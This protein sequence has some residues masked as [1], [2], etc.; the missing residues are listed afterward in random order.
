MNLTVNT[1]L[2]KELT[3]K[4]LKGASFNKL[5]PIT[6][7][8]C[9]SC[10]AGKLTLRTTDGSNYLYINQSLENEDFYA[11]VKADV[12]GK[13]IAKLTCDTV[14]ITKEDNGFLTIVGNGKYLVELA[15]DDGN[16]VAFPDPIK[17][18]AYESAEATVSSQDI[19]SIRNIAKPALAVTMENPCYTGYYC[20]DKRVI[21]TDSFMICGLQTALFDS[22][23]LVS[24]VTMDLIDLI[25][26][27]TIRV[28]VPQNS[29]ELIMFAEDCVV[30]GH[31][32]EGIE[33]YAVDAI[34]QLLETP[35]PKKCAVSKS[36]LLAI[37][38]RLALFV[39]VYDNNGIYITFGA[40]GL[41]ISSKKSS[42][43]E[44]VNYIK[45]PED[46]QECTYLIDVTML[47]TQVKA[48]DGD[49]V[50]IEF[51]AGQAIKFVSSTSVQLVALLEDN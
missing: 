10:V 27:D 45:A 25:T 49:A 41:Q 1:V 38:D 39:D 12:F 32:M 3:S 9:I 23:K 40:E 13:L 5:L 31:F 11:V 51:G 44:T 47:Q 46:V 28:F 48:Y 50:E 26:A 36:E 4:A 42:G 43:V 35:L 2:M 18:I 21:A 22:P 33:D 34:S 14:N 16:E 19:L 29:N 6:S 17:D 15:M 8:M 7:L 24:P 30:Y 20:D 37:L